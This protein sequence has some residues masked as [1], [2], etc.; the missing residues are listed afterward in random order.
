MTS[1]ATWRSSPTSPPRSPERPSVTS[2][3]LPQGAPVGG[4]AALLCLAVDT[5][6]CRL[7]EAH[8]S[9]R[10]GSGSQ[11]GE[12]WP[13]RGSSVRSLACPM[14]SSASVR[15]ARFAAATPW[16]TRERRPRRSA[17]RTRSWD[18][19]RGAC[20][21]ARPRRDD[22]APLDHRRGCGRRW[23]ARGTPPYGLAAGPLAIET[24][25]ISAAGPA[26]RHPGRRSCRPTR[27]CRRPTGRPPVDHPQR[28]RHERCRRRPGRR[29]TARSRAWS[30]RWR[31]R[32]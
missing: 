12:R 25:G 4:V 27:G 9:Q 10:T 24:D 16:P 14:M 3:P 17:R 30:S 6:Q 19:S 31:G 13:T 29:S 23:S 26:R 1:T 28:R 7:H 11:W 32:G 5:R 15:P 18:A 20:P 8:P 22:R 2:Q 21:A